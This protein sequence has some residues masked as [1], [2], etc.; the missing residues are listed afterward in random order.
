MY[1]G[2]EVSIG[3]PPTENGDWVALVV[4]KKKQKLIMAGTAVKMELNALKDFSISQSSDAVYYIDKKTKVL[5]I[6][7]GNKK[8]RDVYAAAKTV[9]KGETGMYKAVFV[10]Y[11][12]NDGE[13]DYK[14]KVNV[15]TIAT[16]KNKET[17]KPL[18][19][20]D[21]N[22]GVV[23]LEKGD[24]IEVMSK[25][26]TNR[27]IPENDE[28]AWARGRWQSILLTPSP[29][30]NLKSQLKN[31]NAFGPKNGMI[32]VEAEN[33]HFKSS[34]GSPR[35]WYVRKKGET[36][37]F[38]N[39]EDHLESA[40]NKSY[41]EAL[42]DTRVTHDDVLTVG[43]NF[44]P[45]PGYGGMVAYKVKIKSPGKYYVWTRA[46]SSGP[47]DNGLHVGLNNKWPE[48]GQRIQLCQGKNKWTWTSA[49]RVP[50]NHCGVPNT[51]YLEF[52]HRGEYIVTF[53]IRED[54]FEFDKFI[55]TKNKNYK[56]KD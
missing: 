41:I 23:Y 44:F 14:I 40:S 31:V 54:G 21:S 3:L 50:K 43:E 5:G 4:N 30:L 49:Q 6:N 17:K 19:K 10:S 9:F 52:P 53:S 38:K 42:P 36:I 28:T 1:G 20:Y 48:S 51:I 29:D 16:V 15:E 7:A 46:Y 32:T 26:V 13:S 55:L 34:N 47:E 18:A 12:E 37:E 11:T 45:F 8:Y 25:A 27:K 2:K 22:L 56:P 39:L 33:F 24:V 35:D